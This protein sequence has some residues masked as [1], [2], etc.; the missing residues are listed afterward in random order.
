MR[1]KA[2]PTPVLRSRRRPLV[3]IISIGAFLT[4]SSQL[5]VHVGDDNDEPATMC[6]AR[7]VDVVALISRFRAGASSAEGR[8][9]TGMEKT[10][11][12]PLLYRFLL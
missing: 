9:L 7:N 2:P 5:F 10:A 12:K 1:L 8:E 6:A 3:S 4:R 11:I